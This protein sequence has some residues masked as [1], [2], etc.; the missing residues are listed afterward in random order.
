MRKIADE[1]RRARLGLR[2]GSARPLA[3][4]EDAVDA[5]VALHSSDPATVYL[6]TWARVGDFVP[7]DLEGALYER[8][9]LVRMLGMRRTLFV[10]PVEVAAVMNEACTKALVPAQRRLLVRMLGEQG[11]VSPDRVERWVDRVAAETLDALAA[12]GEAS[13]RELTKDVPD[14]G[15]KLT[16]GEGKTWRA[17]VGVSTRMLFLLATEGRIL[18]ARPLGSWISGQY[19]WAR[20]VDWLGSPLAA[21]D[22]AEASAQ[23]LTRWLRAFG[24]ASSVDIRWWTGWTARLTAATLEAIGAVEVGLGSGVGY[25]L[26]NDVEPV[27]KPEPWV[28]L[29]PGLD[30]TIMGW[31][32]RDWYLGA[33][34]STLFD[35]NGNAGPSVWANGKVVGG[36]SHAD[37]GQVVVKLLEP[38]DAKTKRMI[39]AERLR[40]QVWLGDVHIKPRFRTPLERSLSGS[41][42]GRG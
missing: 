38:V 8:R 39:E 32:E 25:V 15:L 2:H 27:A 24:P 26:P 13:A 22:H 41:R 31:K 4:A 11:L 14:L 19:R 30:P 20:T 33:H 12:R 36:W 37:E 23:L 35:T 29:L 1:E 16:F 34:A 9:S 28:A 3:S 42:Q 40:L 10:V 17:S 18:R 6:S 21:M 7:T 5:M